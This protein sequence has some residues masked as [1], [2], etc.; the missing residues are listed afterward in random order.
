MM[1]MGHL[2]EVLEVLEMEAV[3]AFLLL[4]IQIAPYTD[5]VKVI[6]W[7]PNSGQSITTQ[8]RSSCFAWRAAL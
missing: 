3:H 7:L 5:R 6:D 8:E 4:K 2:R 1:T